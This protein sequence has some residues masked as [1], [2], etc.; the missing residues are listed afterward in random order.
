MIKD[1]LKKVT[2]EKK[3][4]QAKK[5]SKASRK[6]VIALSLVSIIGFLNIMSESFFN[7]SFFGY[8]ESSWLLVLGIGLILETSLNE[9]KSIK[10]NGLNSI[11][12]GK[13]TMI[14]VGVMAVVAAIL[15]FPQINFQNPTFSAVKGIISILAIV[16]I[17]IQTWISKKE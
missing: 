11:M 16:F 10:D 14:V 2:I 4:N 3:L 13:V 12:L 1:K 5:K 15:S 9:L 7:F 17:I 8:I 6:F